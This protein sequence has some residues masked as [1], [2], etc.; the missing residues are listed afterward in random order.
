MEAQANLLHQ[1]QHLHP[2]DS[3]PN[4][5]LACPRW[6]ATRRKACPMASRLRKEL[7]LLTAVVT[8]HHPDRQDEVRY[9]SR[10]H[11]L[12]FRHG[13]HKSSED[14]RTLRTTIPVPSDR[15]RDLLALRA[16]LLHHHLP[17]SVVLR[18]RR[19]P[20]VLR[21]LPLASCH[22]QASSLLQ[23]SLRH[24]DSGFREVPDGHMYEIEARGNAQCCIYIAPEQS[25]IF[26]KERLRL[27]YH[28]GGKEFGSALI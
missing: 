8:L 13:H 20:E 5:N 22:H 18:R 17:V 10:P 11:R 2:R 19:M 12:A 21:R 1:R 28:L 7:P 23:A 9:R 4:N 15:R 25:G 27:A 6:E 26:Q 16:T 24:V 3:I 14:T